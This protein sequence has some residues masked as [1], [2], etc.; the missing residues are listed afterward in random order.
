MAVHL[1]SI[2]SP[3]FG[4]LTGDLQTM[5]QFA[6]SSSTNK[7]VPY[8]CS[9]KDLDAWAVGPNHRKLDG[10]LRYF[11]RA[12]DGGNR[13]RGKLLVFQSSI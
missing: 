13:H 7:D 3:P 4:T 5:P 2:A 6:N 9:L 12:D 11:A 10:V 1:V 8:F